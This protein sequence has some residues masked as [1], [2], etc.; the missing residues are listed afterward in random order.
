MK[1]IDLLMYE[2]QFLLSRLPRGYQAAFFFPFLEIQLFY[3]GWL[4]EEL[5][6]L[7]KMS[8]FTMKDPVMVSPNPLNVQSEGGCWVS[9]AQ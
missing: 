4:A 1:V 9:S 6:S 5:S 7:I 8:F 2:H 3:E